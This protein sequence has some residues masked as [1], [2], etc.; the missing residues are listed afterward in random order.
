MSALMCLGGIFDYAERKDRL[1]E[2][3]LE[4]AEPSVWDDPERAQEL[5]KERASLEQIVHTI[6]ALTS[7]S[8]DAADLLEPT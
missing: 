2:V 8:A 5:G 4:L 1:A 6:D 7:G 3:E